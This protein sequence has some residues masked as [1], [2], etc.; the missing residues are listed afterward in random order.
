MLDFR[1]VLVGS[2]AETAVLH[3]LRQAGYAAVPASVE[4]LFPMLPAMDQAV[5]EALDLAA[6]LRHLPDILVL[7]QGSP[8][9]LV[10]VK[11]RRRV[12]RDTLRKLYEKLHR[13]QARFPDAHTVVIRGTSPKGAAARVD[14]LVRVLPPG[15]LE[16]ILAADLFYHTAAEGSAEEARLEPLWCALRP[17]TSAFDRL[18]G[19]REDV[20][21]LVPLVRAL[22]E[23]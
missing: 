9:M 1:N 17:L 12:D 23:L 21:R 3:L 15:R 4:S 11:F 16:L 7:P 10:E 5:Y 6:E 20:D 14:D 13:Q 19:R 22:A 2:I 18:Q 8:S